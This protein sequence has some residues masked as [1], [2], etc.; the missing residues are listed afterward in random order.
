MGKIRLF[1]FVDS[2]TGSLPM[3]LVQEDHIAAV[4]TQP[5]DNVSWSKPRNE[6]S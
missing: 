3:V 6:A 2:Y 4:M 5:A 1:L